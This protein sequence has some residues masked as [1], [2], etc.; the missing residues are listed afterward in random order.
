MD[1]KEYNVEVTHGKQNHP[2]E[3]ARFKVVADLL[4]TVFKGKTDRLNVVDV[5]CGDAFFLYEL[6]KRFTNCN[7]FAV[8]TAFTTESLTFFEEKYKDADIKFFQNLSDISPSCDKIDLI[9]LLD[10]I[11]HVED[12]VALLS[13][14]RTLPGFH[15]ETVVAVTVPAYQSLFCSHD[16]WLEHH[17]RYSVKMLKK[18][19][20]QAGFTSVK[21][22]Y[23]FF[24]LLLPRIFQKSKERIVKPNIKNTTGIGDWN[25][26][27]FSSALLKNMLVADY[28]FFKLFRYIG[29]GFPGLSCYSISKSTSIV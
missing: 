15:S 22:G 27:K 9:L 6:S 14:L 21:S 3:Y 20:Q 13:S 26:D 24:S 19:L 1:V 11:E 8:D 2:W 23:F 7:F 10:V 16:E 28:K 12:E 29:L 18:R 5:G 25:G 17:R 4:H